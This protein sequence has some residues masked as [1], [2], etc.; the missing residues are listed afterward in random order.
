MRKLPAISAAMAA[1]PWATPGGNTLWLTPILAVAALSP[2]AGGGLCSAKD[3][4]VI[5]DDRAALP[6]KGHKQDAR[7]FHRRVR[8][9]MRKAFCHFYHNAQTGFGIVAHIERIVEPAQGYVI[10]FQKEIVHSLAKAQFKRLRGKGRIV[11]GIV[12][13]HQPFKII[14]QR[15]AEQRLAEMAALE[16]CKLGMAAMVVRSIYPHVL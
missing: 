5:I 7:F 3:T 8:R 13:A 4:Y 16:L 12:P 6:R 2:I 9:G 15:P 14:G 11:I 10:L 1:Y